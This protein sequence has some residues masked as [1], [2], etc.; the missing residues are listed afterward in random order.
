MVKWCSVIIIIVIIIT[1]SSGGH[2]LG[3]VGQEEHQ[4]TN[5]IT[6]NNNS[7]IIII[8][9]TI[10]GRYGA[11]SRLVARMICSPDISTM[12]GEEG[13]TWGSSS[14]FYY[15][16]LQENSAFGEPFQP[17]QQAEQTDRL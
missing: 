9:G 11:Y 5:S 4:S 3:N 2:T 17:S 14:V 13:K 1:G 16:S 10:R 12:A 7:D 8:K 15:S 6:Y